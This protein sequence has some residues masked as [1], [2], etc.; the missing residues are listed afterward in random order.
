ML[1]PKSLIDKEKGADLEGFSPEL[2]IV[3]IGGG[4][5][6]E[7][8]LVI[9]P[10]SETV[11]WQTYGKWMQSYR[12]LPF[13]Y[14]QW[15]N[16]LRWEMRTRLF[17]RTSRVHLAGGPHCPRHGRRGEG[18]GLSD[19]R[20]LPRGCRGRPRDPGSD[21]A[22]DSVGDVPGAVYTDAIEGLM[23]DGKALHAGTPTSWVE[24]FSHAYD[25]QFLNK[26]GEPGVCVGYVLGLLD[27][28]GRR[29]AS[30]MT[31][32]GGGGGLR[33]PP[34]VAPVQVVVIPIYKTDEERGGVL[35]VANT[36]KEA[37]AKEF[38]PGQG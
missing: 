20:G 15:C 26:D 21:R 16:V 27:Q 1:I 9:R 22:E 30:T 11:I 34:A 12:D 38:R 37:L 14:N 7:E 5:V 10:T 35:E 25:C 8:P 33:L 23:R 31:A 6:L 28:D 32:H 36:I 19:A 24:N 3:T 4:E 2:A 13:L 17:L 29:D 18:R